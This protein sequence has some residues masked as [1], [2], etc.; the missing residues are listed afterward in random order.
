MVFGQA[1]FRINVAVHFVCA[2]SDAYLAPDAFGVTA[3]YNEFIEG[4]VHGFVKH[5]EPPPVYPVPG[6]PFL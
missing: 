5:S 3:F 1:I 4:F 6:A 2:L